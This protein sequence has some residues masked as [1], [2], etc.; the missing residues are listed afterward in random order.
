MKKLFILLVSILAST[1]VNSC[2][3]PRRSESDNQ[4]KITATEKTTTE[5]T[6][7]KATEF[8]F[9]NFKNSI[10]GLILTKRY[11]KTKAT[12]FFVP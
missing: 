3:E 7:T 6:T 5:K 8:P 9:Q 4:V 1:N 2:D 12:N 11:S 10:V